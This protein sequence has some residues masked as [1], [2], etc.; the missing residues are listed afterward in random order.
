MKKAYVLLVVFMGLVLVFNQAQAADPEE[1]PKELIM[2]TKFM[3]STTYVI[4]TSVAK[5]INE[6]VEGVNCYVKSFPGVNDWPFR[7]EKGEIDLSMLSTSIA[8][9]AS[10]GRRQ[11]EKHGPFNCRMLGYG[12]PVYLG[13]IARKGAGI[14]TVAD[15]KG[16][17]WMA[18]RPGSVL[19]KL[20]V[21]AVLKA[22]NWT[23]NDLTIMSHA[24]T[25][26]FM[27]AI[28]ERR[29][30][31]IFW[32]TYDASPWAVELAQGGYIEFVSD[33][34]EH[35]KIITQQIV[36][37]QW[38]PITMPAGTY[39]GQDKDWNTFAEVT[40]MS[41]RD[42][43]AD[44]LVYAIVRAL[45]DN[46]DEW[47]A[48]HSDVKGYKLPGSLQPQRFTVPLHPGA[49]KY[50]KEKGYWKA[51]QEAK[52]RAMLAAIEKAREAFLERKK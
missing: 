36:G 17:K 27:N 5:L 32:P 22:H 48:Y 6:H 7:T 28:R 3:P 37:G 45:F 35:L 29:V 51:E 18:I 50:Y 19:G 14:K 39:K 25:T 13:V 9:Q 30:D 38:V 15:L 41:A 31:A 23:E 10:L 47:V 12:P 1:W 16:K 11:Y 34:P 20:V 49:I 24:S 40:S 33:T 44:D 42:T 46:F 26:E 52:Q 8:F 4:G 43:L 2:A 21:N